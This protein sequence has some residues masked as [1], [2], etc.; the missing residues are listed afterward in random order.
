LITNILKDKSTKLFIVLGGFFVANALIAEVI[1]VKLF[2]LE[3]LF[4]QIPFDFTFLGESGLSFTLSAGVLLWPVVFISTDIINEYYGVKGVKFLSFLTAGFISIAFIAFYI[5][6]KLPAIDWWIPV[7]TDKGVPDMQA[8]FSQILGQG[9][10]IILGSISAFI[11]GQIIDAYI[12]RR[13]KK[14]TGE[15]YI[16]LRATFSTVISQFIDSFVVTFVAF[17]IFQGWTFPKVLAICMVGYS[18]KFIMSILMT[19]VVYLVHAAIEKYLGHQL[20]SQMKKQAIES[21]N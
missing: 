21:N 11:L 6:I 4:G 1:G 15:K 3:K 2:S 18:Y 20:A 9:M 8:A 12:F 17:Y 13:I 14:I 16:W 10:N 19:P 5:S 7:N